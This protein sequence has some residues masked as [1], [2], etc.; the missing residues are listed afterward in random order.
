LTQGRYR[1]IGFFLIGALV[2]LALGGLAFARVLPDLQDTRTEVGEVDRVQTPTRTDAPESVPEAPADREEDRNRSEEERSETEEPSQREEPSEEAPTEEASPDEDQYAS[3]SQYASGAQ[4]SEDDQ[5][6]EEQGAEEQDA[7]EDQ[8]SEDQY[9][10]ED[11]YASS[12]QYEE[13]E[14][15]ADEGQYASG[16]PAP[17][18]SGLYLTVPKM[19]LSGDPVANGTDEATLV[20]G[21]GKL[22]S[23]GFPWQAG[24][25]TYIASHVYGYEG[26]GSWQH[27]AALPSMTYGDEII[28]TDDNGTEYRYVVSEILTV[29]PTD[30]WVAAPTGEDMVSLQ[31][32]VG[33]GWSERL[34]V[35]AT[36][37]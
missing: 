36:R 7:S 27:F 4:Y 25:N 32:C 33:P 6:S 29:A 13:E 24:S 18:T 2:A 34:V 15:S 35:R 23:S 31:T 30:V 26:T 16:G 11:Q 8:Y 12:D 22:A 14:Q 17:A 1:R 37:V 9:A 5:Y 10:D 28:L 21:A 20:N 3:D 19:G